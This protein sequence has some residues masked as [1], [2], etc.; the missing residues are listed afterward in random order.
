MSG[1]K[2][3]MPER[4]FYVA[5]RAILAAAALDT[6]PASRAHPDALLLA[7]SRRVAKLWRR[8]DRLSADGQARHDDEE[9]ERR[10]Q[11]I[12]TATDPLL[13]YVCACQSRTLDGHRARAAAFLAT[14]ESGLLMRA[15]T[16]DVPGEKL[17]AALVLDLLGSR[18]S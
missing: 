3:A 1:D 10:L 4:R 13:E 9:H 12:D 7:T 17:L 6:L 18:L 8:R 2:P 14:D 11:A 5:D 16:R 15:N